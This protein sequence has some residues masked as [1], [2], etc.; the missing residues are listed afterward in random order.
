VLGAYTAAGDRR[1]A[2]ARQHIVSDPVEEADGKLVEEEADPEVLFRPGEVRYRPCDKMW[3]RCGDDH[4]PCRLACCGTPASASVTPQ[5][6]VTKHRC[7][8]RLTA[9]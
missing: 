4:P 9:M 8:R 5:S 1:P 2:T 7:Q 3:Y 6:A